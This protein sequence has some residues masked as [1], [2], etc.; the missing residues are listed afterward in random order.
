METFIPQTK[1]LSIAWLTA[2]VIASAI[3]L[4]VGF[5]AT[6]PLVWNLSDRIGPVLP[7]T[8]F[9]VFGGAFFGLGVGFAI[10]LAQWLVLRMRREQSVGWLIGSVVGGIVGGIIAIVLG[11][12]FNENGGNEAL[13]ALTIGL[14]GA[15]LGAGQY[16]ADRQNTK[17]AFWILASAVGLT[18]GGLIPVNS[19]NSGI[20]HIVLGGLLYG[21]LGAV[22]LWVL[23]RD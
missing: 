3:G 6:L 4:W 9:Q 19:A 5:L 11:G 17:S 12:V 2:W 10:G 20:I 1:R 16:A 18:L 22:A 13:T 23:T 14:F 8:V 15:I 7:K 21:T